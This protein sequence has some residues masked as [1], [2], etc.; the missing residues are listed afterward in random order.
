MSRVE[1]VGIASYRRDRRGNES[2]PGD[3][4]TD[5][6]PETARIGSLRARSAGS[7]G[8]VTGLCHFPKCINTRL[9]TYASLLTT[10]VHIRTFALLSAQEIAPAEELIE[11]AQPNAM[12]P[13]LCSNTLPERTSTL[14]ATCATSIPQFNNT[15]ATLEFGIVKHFNCLQELL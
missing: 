13:Q 15:R 7:I 9:S 6:R 11:T 4:R 3:P 14:S 8:R 5:R 2:P 10:C 1:Q 12:S